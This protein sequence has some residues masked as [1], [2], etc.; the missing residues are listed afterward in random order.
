M[1]MIKSGKLSQENEVE[2]FFKK[3]NPYFLSRSKN[4]EILSHMHQIQ[5]SRPTVTSNC[6]ILDL[7]NHTMFNR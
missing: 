2:A 7:N 4:T 6:E 3:K 1:M 5:L